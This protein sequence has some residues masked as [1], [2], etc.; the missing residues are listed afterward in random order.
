M[1]RKGRRS[2]ESKPATEKFERKRGNAVEAVE[3]QE[4]QPNAKKAGLLYSCH[5]Y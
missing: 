4:S 3:T 1:D 5:L 2:S